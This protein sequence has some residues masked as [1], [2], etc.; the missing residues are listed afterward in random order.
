VLDVGCGDGSF[1]RMAATHARMVIGVD[2]SP[3]MLANARRLSKGY[4]NIEYRQGDFS[5]LSGV[6]LP[7]SVDVSVAL[8]A[9]CC[10][11]SARQLKRLF[12]QLRSAT[13]DGG[14]V[15]VQV[16]HPCDGLFATPS[17]WFED[18]DEFGSYFDCGQLVRR[19]LRT[20]DGKWIA[21]ARFHFP[22]GVYVR[23]ILAAGLEIVDMLEPR[24]S[25]AVVAR[26]PSLRREA[27]LPSSVI[28]VARLRR[29][30]A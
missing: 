3:A 15:I 26:H 14:S 7:R 2:L 28:F 29:G 27:L 19:R 10:A 22:L 24:A 8:Y 4:A 5:R 17:A 21:A 1:C 25:R 12:T 9:S 30:A 23:Q 18:V 11:P 13:K 16:P 20:V 6:V